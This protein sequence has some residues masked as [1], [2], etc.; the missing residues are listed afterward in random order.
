MDSFTIYALV[1]WLLYMV[2]YG[3]KVKGKSIKCYILKCNGTCICTEKV[4]IIFSFAS[5]AYN[6]IPSTETAMFKTS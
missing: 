5:D 1:Y 4:D 2:Q 3:I 6:N